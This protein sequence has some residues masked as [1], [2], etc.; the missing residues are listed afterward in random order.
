MDLTTVKDSLVGGK[1][2]SYENFFDDL[3]LIWSNCKTFNMSQSDIYKM[4]EECERLSVNLVKQMS[5]ELGLAGSKKAKRETEYFEKSDD[6]DDQ[7]ITLDDRIAFSEKVR[8]L[9]V[10]QMTELVKFIQNLVPKA[11]ED[12]DADKLQIKVDELGPES[13]TEIGNLVDKFEKANIAK[14]KEESKGEMQVDGE[15]AKS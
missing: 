11:I 14:Y 1:F 13:F 8:K 9:N 12:I 3:Q 4:A 5:K 2:T 7:S 6:E 15:E 10:E